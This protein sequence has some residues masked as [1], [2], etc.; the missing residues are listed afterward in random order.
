MKHTA[1]IIVTAPNAQ[2]LK[3]RV[4]KM[5][6]LINSAEISEDPMKEKIVVDWLT[7]AGIQVS[8]K[9]EE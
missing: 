8:Y 3:E 1:T 7:I 2:N 5:A 6:E 4:Q 9:I